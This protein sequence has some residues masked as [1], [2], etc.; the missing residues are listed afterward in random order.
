MIHKKNI[1]KQLIYIFKVFCSK[2]PQQQNHYVKKMKKINKKDTGSHWLSISDVMAGLFLF[3]MLLVLIALQESGQLSGVNSTLNETIGIR[4]EILEGIKKALE[5]EGIEVIIDKDDGTLSIKDEI[6]FAYGD[7]TL[8]P[9]GQEVLSNAMPKISKIV[10]SNKD[11]IKNIISIDINGY[12]S[13]YTPFNKKYSEEMMQLSLKRSE[14]IWKFTYRL[15]GFPNRRRF[16]KKLKVGGWGNQRAETVGD[17]PED[18]KVEFGF[19]F[20]EPWQDLMDK[21]SKQ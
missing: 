3:M 20:Y 13:E 9:K 7:T 12:A 19:K 2:Y 11:Y 21:L 4:I 17:R 6:L 15:D 14:V 1:C 8:I 5:D 18:R 16:F 10:F